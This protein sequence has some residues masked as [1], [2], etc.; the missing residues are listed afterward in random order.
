MFTIL[1]SLKNSDITGHDL[2]TEKGYKQMMSDLETTVG[3]QYLKAVHVN[4]SKGKREKKNLGMRLKLKSV[5]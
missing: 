1:Q 4:D 3:L 5:F 2:S